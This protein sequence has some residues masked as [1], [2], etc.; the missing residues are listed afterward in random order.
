[1][2]IRE[3]RRPAALWIYLATAFLAVP[4]ALAATWSAGWDWWSG[5]RPQFANWWH[6]WRLFVGWSACAVLFANIVGGRP[7]KG[8]G[9]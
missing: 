1:M 7:E 2:T 5:E 8:G 3:G 6:V 9:S 4:F